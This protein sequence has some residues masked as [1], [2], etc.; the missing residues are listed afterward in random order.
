MST[1]I[2]NL[3]RRLKAS[4]HF[5]ELAE[6]N[7]NTIRKST[8]YRSAMILY[9]SIAEAMTYEIVKNAT[10]PGHIIGE[11]VQLKE[12]YEIRAGAVNPENLYICK[13]EKKKIHIDDKVGD[14]GKYILYLKNN[15]LISKS[16][17]VQ[18]NWAR[19]ERNKI[20]LQGLASSDIRYTKKKIDKAGK[21][22]ELLLDN[23]KK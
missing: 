3:V 17:Y 5:L 15:N 6:K 20:H 12:L 10:A 18:L 4:V 9:C 22:I 13:K 2:D 14:F 1:L 7:N 8:Y 19:E 23:L 21:V 16:E 11:S